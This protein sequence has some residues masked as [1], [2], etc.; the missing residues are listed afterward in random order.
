[1][2]S[3]AAPPREHMAEPAAARGERI[4]A[5]APHPRPRFPA[6]RQTWR[7][8]WKGPDA[9]SRGLMP[10]AAEHCQG[11]RCC[12]LLAARPQIAGRDP[13][14]PL[15]WVAPSPTDRFWQR[16]QRRIRPGADLARPP[17]VVPLAASRTHFLLCRSQGHLD[18]SAKTTRNKALDRNCAT[19]TRMA[20]HQP[21]G[22]AVARAR[23]IPILRSFSGHTAHGPRGQHR[24]P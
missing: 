20:C 5:C 4:A 1:M 18:S 9:P 22:A 3:K 6:A 12:L 16:W 2:S 23:L 15:V 14:N 7:P 17:S 10:A 11:V 19:G 24:P 13:G 21:R 8:R